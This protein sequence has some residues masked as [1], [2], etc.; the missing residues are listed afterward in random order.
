MLLCNMKVVTKTITKLT[1]ILMTKIN[2]S[3]SYVKQYDV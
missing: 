2:K 1:L 3:D